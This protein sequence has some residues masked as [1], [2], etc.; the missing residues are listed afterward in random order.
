MAKMN[1]LADLAA[2]LS[3]RLPPSAKRALYRL[4][5]L[6][7]AL[8]GV[9]NR[10]VP[11]GLTVVDIA[12]GDL[13]GWRCELDLQQEK[14]YW[15]GTYEMALQAA[16][17][18]WVQPGWVAYDLGAN[19]GY[20]SLLLARAAGA[21]GQV[22]AIEALPENSVR[23]RKNIQLNDLEGRVTVIQAAVAD[24]DA[25][26]TFLVGPSGATGKAA[27]SAGR[28]MD[29]ESQITVTGASLDTLVYQQGRPL[30]ELI[31]I[32]IEGGEVLALA[33]MPR[34]LAEQRPVLFLELHGQ[35]AARAA[36]DCL[37]GHSYRIL[38]MQPG[39]APVDRLEDLDWKAYLVAEPEESGPAGIGG[40]RD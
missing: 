29:Y 20:I 2:R 19:I 34:L 17:R 33:G 38:R 21:D 16:I 5:P 12:G 14:D 31:K 35:E 6:T 15:L 40:A 7:R 23:L 30:P 8:R 13:Q 22:V 25:P 24:R 27:G 10:S 37:T 18:R 36:W 1:P 11:A 32:D 28:G 26:L 9:L 39:Y 4:G 3:R